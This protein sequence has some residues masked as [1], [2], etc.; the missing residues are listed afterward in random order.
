MGFARR[1]AVLTEEAIL[2]R[3]YDEDTGVAMLAKV[4]LDQ[5][6]L[7]DSQ[8]ELGKQVFSPI[9]AE[10]KDVIQHLEG[11][12]DIDPVVWLIH[13]SRDP[14]PTIRAAALD[15][16]KENASMPDVLKRLTEMAVDDPSATVRTQARAMLP[17]E[18][19]AVLPQPGES[20]VAL[21][22]LP[23]SPALYPRAN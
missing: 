20:T 12:D 9:V 14:E 22:P 16:L 1:P 17:K 18:A 11:R 23:G 7:S 6:G 2:P 4:V 3:L 13:L 5:R 8:I 10:R 21:P 19:A 15:A